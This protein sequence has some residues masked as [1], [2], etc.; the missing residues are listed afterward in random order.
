MHAVLRPYVTAGVSL[1]GASA[2][3][4][5]PISPV[6]AALPDIYAPAR[7]VSTAAVNLVAS[8]IDFY[9][10]VFARTTTNLGQLAGR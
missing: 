4:I 1:I 10:E 7:A 8:P 9:T 3:A 5:S 6:S 2:I